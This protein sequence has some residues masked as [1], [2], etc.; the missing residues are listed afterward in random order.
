MRT[1]LSSSLVTRARRKST[2][3]SQFSIFS[4]RFSLLIRGPTPRG[5]TP[6]TCVRFAIRSLLRALKLRKLS[7]VALGDGQLDV[8]RRRGHIL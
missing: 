7:L 3:R 4:I 2:R 8:A 1:F 6:R 5:L